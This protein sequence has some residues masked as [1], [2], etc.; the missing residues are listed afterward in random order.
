L[1]ANCPGARWNLNLN[2]NLNREPWSATI[3]ILNSVELVV[4][5]V[6]ST[7]KV[8]LCKPVPCPEVQGADLSAQKRQFRPGA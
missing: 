2:Q 1:R 7:F 4:N 3:A 5:P 8:R 6:F